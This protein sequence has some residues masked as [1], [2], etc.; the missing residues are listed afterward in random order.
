MR[1]P[2]QRPALPIRS[3]TPDGRRQQLLGLAARNP[4]PPGAAGVAAAARGARCAALFAWSKQ[5][6][7]RAGSAGQRPGHLPDQ[8]HRPHAR[9]GLGAGRCRRRLAGD[10]SRRPRGRAHGPRSGAV[11]GR[12]GAAGPAATGPA[13]HAAGRHHPA[14]GGPGPLGATARGRPGRRPRPL[15]AGAPA[16]A[17][18]AHHRPPPGRQ[19]VAQPGRARALA[20]PAGLARRPR[21]A[22]RQH[23]PL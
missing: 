20:H 8:P 7:D 4:G 18:A 6:G 17:D 1:W 2:P 19:P 5:P 12:S 14:P 13:D 23:Q 10:R 15:A 16:A 22:Q 21:R 11:S 3:L 9:P